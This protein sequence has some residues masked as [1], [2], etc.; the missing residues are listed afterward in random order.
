[1]LARAA[2]DCKIY[3]IRGV[4]S[5]HH[6][7]ILLLFLLLL[8]LPFYLL[9]LIK[10]VMYITKIAIHLGT[11]PERDGDKIYNTCPVFGPDGNM[12]GKYRKVHV[13]QKYSFL[14]QHTVKNV[15]LL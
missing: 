2:K 10:C 4:A 6:L 1:M 5:L 3:L 8:L 12:L 9:F 13:F 14:F 7:V 11:I 15:L